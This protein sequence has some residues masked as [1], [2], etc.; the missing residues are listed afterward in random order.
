MAMGWAALHQPLNDFFLAK[1]GSGTS[2]GI[3]FRFDKYGSILSDADFV[4]PRQPD[5]GPQASVAVEKFSDLVNHVPRDSGDDMTVALSADAV[6]STYFYRLLSPAI[7]LLPADGD[8]VVQ[9]SILTS[10]S[11]AKAAALNVWANIKAAS[12]SGYMIEFKPSMATPADWYDR[13]KG[14]SWTSAAFDISAPTQ[15]S[16]PASEPGLWRLAPSEATLNRVLQGPLI[17]GGYPSTAFGEKKLAFATS[18]TV[19]P[20]AILQRALLPQ[21]TMTAVRIA[22]GLAISHSLVSDAISLQ[23]ATSDREVAADPVIA[24]LDGASSA[25]FQRAITALPV[26]DRLALNQTIVESVETRPVTTDSIHLSFDYCLVTI[27]RPWYVD[28]FVNQ[29]NW[30][31]P[32]EPKGQVSAGVPN[33]MAYLPIGLIAVRNLRITG[34]WDVDDQAAAALATD[35]GPF[36]VKGAGASGG[37]VH[38]GLQTIGWILQQLPE[39]PP[40]DPPVSSSTPPFSSSTPQ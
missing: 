6:D 8:Q 36:R 35:F 28:G 10:F 16:A 40:Q 22:P 24:E 39:L 33:G 11:V 17:S 9:D 2:T 19:V 3:L 7:P 26:S 27:S 12:S 14:D 25:V 21:E 32:G 13:T 5:V 38:D 30:Y 15:S 31:I 23:G 18:K 37:L 4:D 20:E 29:P 34:A 1:F